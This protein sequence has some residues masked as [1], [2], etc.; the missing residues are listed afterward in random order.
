M[1]K[2]SIVIPYLNQTRLMATVFE[3]L[4]KVTSITPEIEFLLID[5]GS[6]EEPHLTVPT[7]FANPNLIRVVRNEKTKGVY[8]SF[9]QGFEETT[10]EIVAFMHSDMVIWE[11]GWDKRV[12]AEFDSQPKLG[13][14]GFIGSNEIDAWGGRG[15][16][17]ASNFMGR[18]LRSVLQIGAPSWTGSPAEPH[19]RRI[20]GFEKAAVVDGCTMII[21]RRA[22]QEIEYREDQPPHHFYD[23]LIACQLLEKGWQIGVLGIECDHFSGQTANQEPAY[24]EMC[25]EWAKENL[26]IDSFEEYRNYSRWFDSVANPSKGKIPHNWDSVI[27]QEAERM[28]LEEYRDL[29]KL[30]PLIVRP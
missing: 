22:W 30:V 18:T 14:I 21:R 8:P 12:I 2:L 23:R 15:L 9:K 27:Y 3:Q 1:K 10:G 16:G 26:G 19:G 4:I 11:E 13:M 6:T 28:F 7:K 20:R 25:R 24:A 5:D 17:T 29:K